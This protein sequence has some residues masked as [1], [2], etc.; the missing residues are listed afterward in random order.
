MLNNMSPNKNFHSKEKKEAIGEEVT[1]DLDLDED[2]TSS[3]SNNNS[4]RMEKEIFRAKMI[5]M[6]VLIVIVLVILLIIGYI[7]SLFL[8]KNY[9]YATVE[10]VMKD[11]AISYFEDNKSRLPKTDDETVEISTSV[12]VNN[13]KMKDLSY[14]L[15]DETCSGKVSILKISSN[16]YNYIPYLSCGNNYTTTSFYKKIIDEKNIV[17]EGFGLYQLNGEYVYRGTEVK[18]YVK[19][20]DSNILWRIVKVNSNNEVV[21]IDDSRSINSFSW[22]ERYN[23]THDGNVGINVYNNSN[24]SSILNSI[25]NN[26]ITAEG[27]NYVYSDEKTYLTKE[28]KKKIVKYEACVGNR[29]LSD[30]SKNGQAECSEKYTTKISLLPVYDFLNASLDVNCTSADKPD[31]QNYNY[32]ANNTNYWLANGTTEDNS[33]VYRVSNLNYIQ[34]QTASSESYV[35]AVIHV[36]TDAMFEKGKGT[37]TNPYIIR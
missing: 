21:L 29:S 27:S 17:T 22:D 24:I 10:D 20:S 25:Y 36:S 37:K 6:F 16:E 19:F 26:K 30:T 32:L 3:D 23:N 13:K 12:L 18:N 28:E 14:Y 33:K 11:A 8:K 31:C 9:T 2:N 1:Y 7:I 15:K 4:N 5:K 35:R 34:K